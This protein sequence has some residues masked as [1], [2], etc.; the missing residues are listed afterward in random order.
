MSFHSTWF[1]LGL[2]VFLSDSI[3]CLSILPDSS[4][5]LKCFWVFPFWVF[6][7]YLIPVWAKSL[8]EWFHSM[9]F[10]STWFQL[11]LKVFLSLSILSLS[12]LRDSS[13]A[14][15]HFLRDSILSV[16]IDPQTAHKCSNRLLGL[17]KLIL[18]S[19]CGVFFLLFLRLFYWFFYL[20]CACLET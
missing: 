12:I 16:S 20:I 8:S 10:H 17:K 18:G 7:F 3:I 9:S 13:W 2:K 5:G 15:N 14:K 19:F 6:P 11:E 4:W 1:Q